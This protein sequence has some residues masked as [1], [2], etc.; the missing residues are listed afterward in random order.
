MLA[1]WMKS[2]IVTKLTLTS[3]I[4]GARRDLPEFFRLLGYYAA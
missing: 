2:R 3:E 1:G 4:V